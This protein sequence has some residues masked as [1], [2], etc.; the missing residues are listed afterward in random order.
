MG[1]KQ[2]Q[3]WRMLNTGTGWL[4]LLLGVGVL[5]RLI[6]YLLQMPVWGDEALLA[7]NFL[8]RDF[9]TLLRPL[10]GSQVAPIVFLWFE[11]V[12]LQ[13]AGASELSL[14]FFPLLAGVAA[15]FL[16]W[17]FARRTVAPTA[18]VIATGVLAVSYYPVRHSCE[19]KPY[20]FDLL[21]S[22]ALLALAA[23]WL[24]SPTRTWPKFALISLVPLGLGASYPS[25]FVAGGVSIALACGLFFGG[26]R[27]DVLWLVAYNVVLVAAFVVLHGIV[28]AGQFGKT[29]DHMV[30]Y[31]RETFPP[32]QLWDFAVWSVRVHTGNLFAYPVGSRDGGSA[33]TFLLF[34]LGAVSL[35]RVRKWQLCAML[36][37][38]FG[39]TLIAAA[40][41]RYPYGG[42]ARVAQ[43]LAPAIC[44]LMGVGIAW[45]LTRLTSD[46][47]SLARGTTAVCAVLVVIGIVGI[48][49]DFRKPYKT[50][51]DER[52]RQIVAA[53]VG[54]AR[55]DEQLVVIDRPEH[56]PANLQWYLRL[57][58]ERLRWSG[59]VDLAHL[60]ATANDVRTISFGNLAA[61]AEAE[62]LRL[63]ETG[64]V[65]RVADR[66]TDTLRFGA[67]HEPPTVST[68]TRWSVQQ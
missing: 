56:V 43:H 59:E 1:A 61:E 6:R 50:R 24:R 52:A 14:R 31:W 9:A 51:D 34:A 45:V 64:H 29:R 66:A 41:H 12:A 67:A 38:P 60:T 17:H 28:G 46:P 10:E 49:R 57:H 7:L 42:S 27:R 47:K 54:D 32:A 62:R 21:V 11:F 5:W 13:I 35:L 44:L 26:L 22:V 2:L 63:F 39:L 68:R 33:A 40:L 30:T 36:L 3:S 55:P 53:F 25:V 37:V 4:V 16:F 23:E 58:D 20:S 18:A 65:Y 19:I 15:L 8:D 48:A